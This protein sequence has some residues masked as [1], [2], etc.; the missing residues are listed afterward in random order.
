MDQKDPTHIFPVLE[1]EEVAR[2]TVPFASIANNLAAVLEEHGVAIVPDIL[3]EAECNHLSGLFG[4]DLLDVVNKE[5]CAALLEFPN[6]NLSDAIDKVLTSTPQ[7]IPQVWPVGSPLGKKGFASNH[8]FPH[9]RFAWAARLN[10]RVRETYATLHQCA[11]EDLCV[12]V[13][14]VFFTPPHLPAT[15]VSPSLWPHVDQNIHAGESGEWP[16][17]QSVLYVWGSEAP[18]AST[19]IVQ[20]RSIGETYRKVMADERIG[21]IGRGGGHYSALSYMRNR[22]VAN[23]LD[24]DFRQYARRVPVP[25]GGLLLWNSRTMHQ[26]HQG[27]GRLAV[28]ICWEP[29]SRRPEHVLRRKARLC[30]S[31]LPSTHWASLGNQH[32]VAKKVPLAKPAQPA[33]EH[34][35]SWLH[36]QLPFRATLNV[37]SVQPDQA[38]QVEAARERCNDDAV[39]QFLTVDGDA[40]FGQHLLSLLTPTVRDV[41]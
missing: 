30:V 29:R 36:A 28:P 35:D 6:N 17:W 25:A 34:L 1:P 33:P 2:I 9:G 24:Q 11:P 39:N 32:E 16:I 19:T 7:T 3:S 4:E 8:G 31:G 18:G 12:G 15:D 14:L 37:V 23:Q 38:D 27:G 10:S 13:D 26:G 5:A 22:E 41:I 40:E 21:E 20:L